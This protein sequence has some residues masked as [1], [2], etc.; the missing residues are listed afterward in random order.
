MF[1]D[2]PLGML[3]IVAKPLVP[4]YFLGFL[5]PPERVWTITTTSNI[6]STLHAHDK[7]ITAVL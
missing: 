1:I 4:P 5:L 3:G 6:A 7:T 2:G